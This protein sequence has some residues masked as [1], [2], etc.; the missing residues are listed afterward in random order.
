MND[1]RWAP[2]LKFQ[3]PVFHRGQWHNDEKRAIVLLK[4]DEIAHER[5]NLN[6][7]AQ[8]HLI[9]EDATETVVVQTDHPLKPY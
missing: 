4:L 6:S 8:T 9:G 7:L 1:Q 3:A 5:N 2:A